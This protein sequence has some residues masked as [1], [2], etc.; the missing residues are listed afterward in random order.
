M[1]KVKYRKQRPFTAKVEKREADLGQL[2]LW[3]SV[4]EA[5]TLLTH[6]L[7]LKVL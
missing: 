3:I 1:T 6:G 7:L 5:L 4:N 2:L